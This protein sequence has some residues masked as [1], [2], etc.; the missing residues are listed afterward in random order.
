MPAKSAAWYMVA[1]NAPRKHTTTHRAH[2][3]RTHNATERRKR[4]CPGDPRA[5]MCKG[6][7]I[8][9]EAE[10]M[11]TRALHARLPEMNRTALP[12]IQQKKAAGMQLPLTGYNCYNSGEKQSAFMA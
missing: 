11:L 2:H 10:R 8:S 1:L 12:L 4:R 9:S 7:L 3:T 6:C 5:A